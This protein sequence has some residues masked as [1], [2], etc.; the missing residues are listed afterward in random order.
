MKIRIW[1]HG[2]L[3]WKEFLRTS[4]EM[5][6]IRLTI[7]LSDDINSFICI[8]MCLTQI[9]I[10]RGFCKLWPK[11]G[12]TSIKIKLSLLALVM[13]HKIR[14]M[15]YTWYVMIRKKAKCFSTLIFD[16][17]T[18]KMKEKCIMEGE[19]QVHDCIEWL[20]G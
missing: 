18:Y 15:Q 14:A 16:L 2:L 10:F 4:S 20:M 7:V 1:S 9:F 17:I 19:S 12:H 6:N 8:Q 5:L 3:G 13:L 11:F